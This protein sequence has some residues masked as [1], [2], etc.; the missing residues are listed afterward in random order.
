MYKTWLQIKGT[1]SLILFFNLKT[2]IFYLI[3]YHFSPRGHES[4]LRMHWQS[5][6]FFRRSISRANLNFMK[7]DDDM[8]MNVSRNGRKW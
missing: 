6:F 3:Q 4:L 7:D 1:Q 8:T 2:Q 5:G